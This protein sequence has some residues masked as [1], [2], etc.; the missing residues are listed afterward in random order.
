MRVRVGETKECSICNGNSDK[1]ARGLQCFICGK[2]A[3]GWKIIHHSQG[4]VDAFGHYQDSKG[5]S[6]QL[7]SRYGCSTPFLVWLM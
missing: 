6:V 3:I 5:K 2:E 4:R 7:S 1:V